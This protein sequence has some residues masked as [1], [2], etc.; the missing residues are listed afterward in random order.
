[1]TTAI[2]LVCPGGNG[3]FIANQSGLSPDGRMV[4]H[5]PSG[6]EWREIQYVEQLS[7]AFDPSTLD[8]A[9]L[10]AAFGVG[11]AVMGV[12]L[13]MCWAVRLVISAVRSW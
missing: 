7:E 6:G 3:T 11:F 4:P 1:M 9:Q 8:P 10:S 12:P 2:V 13:V 5:C